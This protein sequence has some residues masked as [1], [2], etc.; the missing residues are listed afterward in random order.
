MTA[1]ELKSWL[2]GKGCRFS[3]GHDDLIVVHLGGKTSQL[4]MHHKD[5]VLGT[6]LIALIK[7]DL[8]LDE[9]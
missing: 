6:G 8:G 7:A 3:P 9:A 2:K 5:K 4:P 1:R